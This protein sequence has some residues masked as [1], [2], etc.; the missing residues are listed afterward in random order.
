MP[1][2]GT[3]LPMSQGFK[4]QESQVNLALPQSSKGTWNF[5][6]QYRFVFSAKYKP[7]VDS[8]KIKETLRVQSGKSS[9]ASQ[10]PSLSCR[11]FLGTSKHRWNIIPKF[12]LKYNN[13]QYLYF[14]MWK[15]KKQKQNTKQTHKAACSLFINEEWDWKYFVQ[16][17]YHKEALS[18]K[19]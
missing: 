14:V 15:I 11:I 2:D 3:M 10:D 6:T 13:Q 12:N 16:S 1:V 8:N 7:F 5:P 9:K 18:A 4:T 17:L 19:T